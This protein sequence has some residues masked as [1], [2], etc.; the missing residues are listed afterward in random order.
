MV[1]VELAAAV[2]TSFFF[3]RLHLLALYC[4]VQSVCSGYS[5]SWM[6]RTHWDFQSL[7][8]P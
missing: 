8:T 3:L 5:S 6:G 7:K 1:D 2:F 4:I